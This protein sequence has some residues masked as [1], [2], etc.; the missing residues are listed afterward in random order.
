MLEKKVKI[1]HHF[2]RKYQ[3]RAKGYSPTKNTHR[4]IKEKAKSILRRV[5]D[6]SSL[7]CYNKTWFLKT[8]LDRGKERYFYFLIQE[9]KKDLE[10]LALV[11]I[12]TEEMFNKIIKNKKE[13]Y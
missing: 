6:L 13:N 10:Q 5:N 7:E 12:Y 3:Q 1:T 2:I 4:N 9:D 11:T 8:K